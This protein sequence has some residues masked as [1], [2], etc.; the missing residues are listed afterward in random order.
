MNIIVVVLILIII[1]IILISIFLGVVFFRRSREKEN[2]ETKET[3]ELKRMKNELSKESSI[4]LHSLVDSGEIYMYLPI[5]QYILIDSEKDQSYFGSFT[6]KGNEDTLLG[7]YSF[8]FPS[9]YIEKNLLKN[10]TLHSGM[11]LTLQVTDYNGDLF[12]VALAVK[13]ATPTL[14]NGEAFTLKRIK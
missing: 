6:F 12:A 4:V 13:E 8:N 9:Q 3:D 1:I 11:M 2:E 10:Y 14:H 5:N 7:D